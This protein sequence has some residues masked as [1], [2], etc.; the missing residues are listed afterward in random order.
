MSRFGLENSLH[1]TTVFILDL[2]LL[3]FLYCLANF[4]IIVFQH[5]KLRWISERQVCF[6]SELLLSLFAYSDWMCVSMIALS[7]C[8]SITNPRLMESMESKPKMLTAAVAVWIYGML[9]ILLQF[10]GVSDRF[11]INLL[12]SYKAQSEIRRKN[13]VTHV[14]FVA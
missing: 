6:I 10:L 4:L 12:H 3:D 11:I 9:I 1:L 8:L 7:R 5:S 2:A 14:G 13:I